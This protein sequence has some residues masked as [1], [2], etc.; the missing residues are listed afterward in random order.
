MTQTAPS[1]DRPEQPQVPAPHI[2]DPGTP[3]P[4]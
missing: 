4:A 3:K 1:V 2:P